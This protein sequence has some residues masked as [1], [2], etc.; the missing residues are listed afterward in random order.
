MIGLFNQEGESAWILWVPPMAQSALMKRVLKNTPIA[1]LDFLPG[2]AIC[3]IVTA[4]ALGFVTRQ[5]TK[6]AAQ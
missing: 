5:L 2:V 4:V 6:R 3:I 1:P